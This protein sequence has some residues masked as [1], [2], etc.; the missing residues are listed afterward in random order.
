MPLESV[1]PRTPPARA[2]A[3]GIAL[4]AAA[5]AGGCT[6]DFTPREQTRQTPPVVDRNA[7]SA[8]ALAEDLQ[9]LQRLVQGAPAEQAEIAAAAQRDYETAPTPSRQLRF[10]LVLATAGHP[11]TDLPRAQ[12]LLRELMANPE[13]LLSGERALAFVELQQIDDHLTL[14]TEN[15]RLQGDAARADR[16]RLSTVNRRL[17]LE[18]DENTRLR[19]ELDQARAKLDAIA[20]IERSLNERKPSN[21]GRPP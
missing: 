20:N 7:A 1:A 14:E 5:L 13:M 6:T 17:Q 21:E 11:A 10:A 18:T 16:E 3:A 19:K 12:R 15:R 2:M 8:A 9:L 4:V